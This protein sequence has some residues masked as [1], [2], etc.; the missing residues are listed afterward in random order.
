MK[1]DKR[2]K[3]AKQK[4]KAANVARQREQSGGFYG[5]PIPSE[6]HEGRGNYNVPISND[7]LID[8]INFLHNQNRPDCN[9]I[10]VGLDATRQVIGNEIAFNQKWIMRAFEKRKQLTGA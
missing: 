5:V 4:T 7:V 10:I 3:R 9:E 1:A 2:A 8:L 6:R